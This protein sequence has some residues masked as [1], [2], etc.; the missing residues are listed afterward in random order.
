MEPPHSSRD[1]EK[2]E[3]LR[4]F[5]SRVEPGEFTDISSASLPLRHKF[6]LGSDSMD[7]RASEREELYECE[8]CRKL[9]TSSFHEC[10]L[11]KR[12]RLQEAK[13]EPDRKWPRRLF[14]GESRDSAKVV[15]S[16]NEEKVCSSE[17]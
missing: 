9:R 16:A 11:E 6:G 3:E 2:L 13:E 4:F 17:T 7:D 1:L 15:E 10:S 5:P 8:N 14:Q 12:R